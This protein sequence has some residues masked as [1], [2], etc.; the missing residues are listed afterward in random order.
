MSLVG[1]KTDDS[2]LSSAISEVIKLRAAA[3]FDIFITQYVLI[4]GANAVDATADGI[5][6]DLE[7]QSEF[8]R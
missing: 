3:K 6:A 8:M 7:E 2:G 1:I 4:C 5:I